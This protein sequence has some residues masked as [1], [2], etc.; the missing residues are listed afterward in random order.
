MKPISL[1]ILAMLFL[2]P[3]SC[4]LPDSADDNEIIVTEKTAR[5]I[6]A[7]NNFGFELYQ[8]I[9]TSDNDYENIMVSPLSVSLALAMTYNGADGET[10]TAMEKAL[11]V[12]GLTPEEI[13]LSYYELVNALKSLDKKVILEIANAIFYR[14]DFQV[15]NEFVTT[16]KKYYSAEVSALDF[17]NQKKALSVINGWVAKKTK[18]KIESI[19]DEISPAHV[20][21]L[22]NAIYFKGVWQ[23]EFN[24]KNTKKLPFYIENDKSIEVE[25]MQRTDF[26]PYASNELFSTVQLPYGKGNYNMYVFLPQKDKTIAD[27][28]GKLNK[29][30]WGSW[31]AGFGETQKVDIKLPRFK[32]EYEITLNDILTEMGM[33]IAFSSSA[34]F[35]KININGGLCIDF[36]KHKTFIE[37]NEEGTEAA[38]VTVVGI[39]ETSAI[40]E[41][42]IVYFTV[43]RPFMYAITEKSTGAILFM[44]TVKNPDKN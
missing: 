18:D 9:F 11:K 40:D 33:G 37:V 1:L 5:L 21:F 16:N 14:E 38:A 23:T 3:G 17:Q 30:N 4:N 22:L 43:D 26:M 44:G 15:E 28:A 10:K 31:L 12:Y 13:N 20:M 24:K 36:V 29:E 25:T 39:R 6:D 27:I 41:P 32:Y 2:F 34:D 19:L 8:N 35:R 7:E 42:E